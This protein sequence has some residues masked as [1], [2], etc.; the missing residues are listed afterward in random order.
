MLHY[1]LFLTD[2]DIDPVSTFDLYRSKLNPKVD[3][4]WQRPKI[5]IINPELEWYDAAPMYPIG[6]DP[7]N[8]HMKNL[9]IKAELSKIYTNHCIRATVIT[10]LNEKGFEARDIMATTGHKSESSIRSY[11]TKCPE[12]KR[13]EV[14]DALASTIVGDTPTKITAKTP[15]STATI[16]T[17]ATNTTDE[18]DA[19]TE[20]PPEDNALVSFPDDPDAIPNDA[21]IKFITQIEEETKKMGYDTASPSSLQVNNSVSNV[22]NVNKPSMFPDIFCPNSTVTINYNINHKSN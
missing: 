14:S 19:P 15:T 11:A 6:R 20:P 22:S 17:E 9:S 10:K 5:N 12:K 3:Y 2:S 4:K 7:L 21:L 8:E 18:N 16:P 1:F 13:R